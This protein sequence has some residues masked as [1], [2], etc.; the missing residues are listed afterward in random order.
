MSK[1]HRETEKEAVAFGAVWTTVSAILHVLIIGLLIYFSPVRQWVFGE[2]EKPATVVTS[3][4][5][6]RF[7]TK[8]LKGERLAVQRQVDE[9]KQLT[10]ELAD[11]R[12]RIFKQ[13]NDD[14]QRRGASV[15][16]RGRPEDLGPVGPDWDIAVADLDIAELYNAGRKIE[17]SAFGIYRQ[18]RVIDLAL[19]Q[20]VSIQAAADVTVMEPPQRADIDPAVFTA[21][22]TS[23]SDPGFNAMK[24]TLFTIRTELG[25]MIGSV[26]QFLDMAHGI[27]GDDVG[28]IIGLPQSNR[29]GLTDHANGSGIARLD[30]PFVDYSPP[31]PNAYEHHWGRGVGP[32]TQRDELFP[33]QEAAALGSVR[34]T[35]GRMLISGE[36]DF[37]PSGW[38]YLDTWYVIGPFDNPNREKLDHKFPPENALQTG[39]DLDAVYVGQEERSIAWQFTQ[40]PE[41]CIIP[42]IP[43][44]GAIW[45]AYTEVYSDK[46]Q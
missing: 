37:S 2:R 40:S 29:S 33:R 6:Q 27:I 32:I 19:L 41:A 36:G 1:F 14:V 30:D 15:A 8:F 11:I 13:F 5:L 3:Q 4:E 24:E 28:G 31:D 26:Q 9:L 7:L 22:I 23:K 16:E 12:L 34:P 20:Q 46:D 18:V 44:E 17:E 43:R 45:Y 10:T 38:M 21:P 42:H 35:P 25:D 39:L